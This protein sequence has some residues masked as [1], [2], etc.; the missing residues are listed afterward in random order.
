MVELVEFASDG[1]LSDGLP[2]SRLRAFLA[3]CW[4]E[5]YQ[6]QLGS[7]TATA[8]VES[9]AGDDLG[10]ILPAT[11][12][13]VV[14]AFHDDRIVGSCVYAA[15]GAI[16]Y[17]WGCYISQAF[18]RSG[19]GRRLIRHVQREGSSAR[20]LQV[21]VLCAS[22]GAIAFYGS[23]G[24]AVV[25]HVEYELFPGCREPAQVMELATA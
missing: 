12:E 25:E 20:R 4:R 16:V 14:L 21:T 11:D 19:T 6:E 24:F 8:M 23:L 10:D 3:T 17:V 13:R 22:T 9:L 18:Q 5:T 2:R 7:D 15:R 1:D